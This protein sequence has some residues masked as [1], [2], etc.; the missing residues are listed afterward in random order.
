[1][2]PFDGK[3]IPV[4]EW[5][6]KLS[7]G[8]A[9]AGEV[10]HYEELTATRLA[11]LDREHTLAL[12]ALGPLEVHG[13]HLP[14]GTD[15]LVA[16]EIQR[17]VIERIR[18]RW[19]ETDFLILPPLFAGADTLRHPCSVDVDSRAIYH[20]VS[21]TGR[22]LAAQ[23]FHTLLLTDNHGAPRHGVAIEKAV[24]RLYRRHGVAVVA[25]FQRLFRRMIE[26]DPQ[27]LADT[28][29]APGSAGD[30]TDQHSGTNETSLMLVIAPGLIL[31][32]WKTLSR[33]A[34]PED[35][36][37]NRLFGA[38]AGVVRWLGGRRLAR[39]LTH[40]GHDLAWIGM[41]PMPTYLGDPSQA[42]AEA[43]ERVL[44][45]HVAEAMAML[46]EVRAGN[47]PFNQ[48]MLWDLRLI[49][50]SR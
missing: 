25:P 10:Y 1:M 3:G 42:S 26:C 47:P 39:D 36:P 6:A 21:A 27:L 49:E 44:E 5:H 15:A 43:G 4:I 30:E 40:L 29:T 22:S 37:L 24:R 34:I 12:M 23:G 48:P 41:D 33:T 31:P 7:R 46:E 16:R 18:E 17:R 28:G 14:V 11:E 45:A 20:L 50:G 35:A 9:M 19:P 2:G 32:L 8:E 13:P 38:V